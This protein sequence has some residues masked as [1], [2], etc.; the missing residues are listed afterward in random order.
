MKNG[1]LVIQL[2]PNSGHHLYF[3]PLAIG[4]GAGATAV[5]NYVRENNLPELSSES[6]ASLLSLCAAEPDWIEPRL[7]SGQTISWLRGKFGIK[8]ERTVTE[9]TYTIL[10]LW[11]A[12]ETNVGIRK[13]GYIYDSNNQPAQADP[14]WIAWQK[15]RDQGSGY[16]STSAELID[17]RNS[18]IV[19]LETVFDLTT[20]LKGSA[21]PCTLEISWQPDD[22][23]PVPVSLIVDFGNTRTIAFGLEMIPRTFGE[24]FA[25]I[26][27]PIVFQRGHDDLAVQA[28]TRI[29]ATD[30]IPDSWAILREPTFAKDKFLPPR[31]L[32]P[33]YVEKKHRARAIGRFLSLLR[34][35]PR[36]V[37]LAKVINRV[38]FMFVKLSPV[39]I[40]P[41]ATD[42]LANSNVSTGQI[43]FLSS[44]KRYAWDNDPV[45]EAGQSVWYMYPRTGVGRSRQ[46]EG[47]LFRFLPR[48]N[49]IRRNVT[50]PKLTQDPPSPTDYSDETLKPSSRPSPPNFGRADVLIWSALAIIERAK[51]QIQSENWRFGHPV[52]RFLNNV[53]VTF[54][55]GWTNLEFSAYWQ[56]WSLAKLVHN[57]TRGPAEP[58]LALDLSLDEAVASQLAIVFSEIRH[59]QDRL[60]VWVNAYGRRRDGRDNVRVL[61][62]DIGGGTV[63]TAVVQYSDAGAGRPSVH[64]LS[65]V[66]FNDS[67]THAGDRLVKDLI[68]TVLLPTLGERFRSNPGLR[69]EFEKFFA[70]SASMREAEDRLKRMVITRSVFIP[71]VYK[72][73]EEIS[74]NTMGSP[75]SP[76]DCGASLPQIEKLNAMFR[77]AGLV[78]DRILGLSFRST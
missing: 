34:M 49:R 25:D 17:F 2:F 35:R 48:N 20:K 73:L 38:P 21:G 36:R 57:W 31:F 18:Q 67:S 45:G 44:P 63:D 43:S 40:G 58:K 71:M 6:Y 69:P 52:R 72:W 77:D 19:D 12:I 16:L 24:S 29:A 65:E 56:A 39:L 1:K 32:W 46:L 8:Q 76:R 4:Q 9:E 3:V 41:E 30:L 47:E 28:V 5:Q 10:G 66:L 50:D 60:S 70:R 23:K 51:E 78:E 37:D 75:K 53:V 59:Q 61:T 13:D 62:I 54:P 27:R 22:A 64:L 26:F 15:T 42:L 33:Q 7:T 74:N 11:C 68:E 14:N 55:P